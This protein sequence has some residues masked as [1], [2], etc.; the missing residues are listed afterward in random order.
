MGA[1]SAVVCSTVGS[2]EGVSA[3]GEGVAVVAE[4]LAVVAEGDGATALLEVS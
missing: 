2:G 4:G 1:A 3:V